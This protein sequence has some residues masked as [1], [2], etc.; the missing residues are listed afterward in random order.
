[1]AHLTALSLQDK[2]NKFIGNSCSRLILL[3]MVRLALKL[4][5]R[6]EMSEK[7]VS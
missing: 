7:D 4:E 5:S 2:D 1:M 6:F 3:V